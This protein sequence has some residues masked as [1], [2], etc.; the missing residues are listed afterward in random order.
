MG[1]LLNILSELETDC[2]GM[3]GSVFP[4]LSGAIKTYLERLVLGEEKDFEPLNEGIGCLQ[5]A[6]RALCRK[7]E[8][9]EKTG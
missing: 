1:R 7:E 9:R 6:Y 5:S 8:F 2:S 4:V 3:K